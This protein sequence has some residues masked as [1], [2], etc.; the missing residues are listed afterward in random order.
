MADHDYDVLVIGS[1][2]GGSVTA[3]RLSEKG[4]R[5]GVLEAGRRYAPDELP[6]T[7]W[8]SRRFL[9]FPKLGMHGIMRM[10]LLKDVFVLSGAGVGG[11]SLVYACTLYEPLDDY[12]RDRQWGHITDWRSELAPHYDQAKRMLGVTPVPFDT[13]ADG[14][15]REVGRRLGVEDTFHPTDVGVYFGDPGERVAD[16]FFGGAGPDRVGCVRCGGC[17][18]GCRYEAKNTLDHNYLYLAEQLG[19][20]VL[21][22]HQVTDLRPLEDGGWGV[23]TER[24]GAWTHRGKRKRVI[25]ADQIVFS[26]GTLGTQK[27]LFKLKETGRLPHL[28]DKLGSLTRTNSEAI[29]GATA[30]D[31]RVDYS[32]GVA[33]TSSIHPDAQTHIEPVRYPKGSGAINLISTLMA[34]GGDDMPRWLRYLGE[35]ARKPADFLRSLSPYHWAQRTVILLVMQSLDNSLQTFRRS[36]PFGSWLWTRQGH[37]E[38]NPTWIPVGN[39]A[40]RQAA[41]VMDGFA[42]GSVFEATMNVPT[43]AHIIGGCPIG[44]APE[45]GVIDP[46]HRL[47]GYEGLHVADG[48]AITANLG[49]NPSL[50]ITAM[51]ERAMAMWPNKG[52]ADARPPLGAGYRRVAPVAPRHPAVPTDAPA[53]LHL[54]IVEAS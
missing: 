47:Y 19:A 14:V 11:G 37:G 21:A 32:D 2:F 49:V 9:F 12:Y 51:A 33:I 30:R 6:T 41:D 26:A 34:D 13:A 35:V 44:D 38:P 31:D 46:Y 18:V 25:T 3:L 22:E 8:D 39:E 27:L 53:A 4:Y 7:N 1:G 23:M 54:P 48:S 40:A 28:S 43:T 20:E 24:P 10:T 16:P 17:M 5:V 52:E 42:L 45:T 36:T 15:L 50:S 29:V